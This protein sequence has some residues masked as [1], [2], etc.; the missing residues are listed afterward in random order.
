LLNAASAIAA[1]EG[2]SGQLNDRLRAGVERAA[3]ALDSGAAAA[4]LSQWIA[5]CEAVTAR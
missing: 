1:Y 2:G 5:A 4:K 3:Q